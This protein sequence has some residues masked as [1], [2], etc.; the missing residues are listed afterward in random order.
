MLAYSRLTPDLRSYSLLLVSD[1]QYTSPTSTD[2]ILVYNI[3]HA[4][5][6]PYREETSPWCNHK[7]SYFRDHRIGEWLL[8]YQPHAVVLIETIFK[9]IFDRVTQEYETTRTIGISSP[10]YYTRPKLGNTT[11]DLIIV[12]V[13]KRGRQRS[14][15]FV[16]KLY[17]MLSEK[18]ESLKMHVD[19]NRQ[20]PRILDK[21]WGSNYFFKWQYNYNDSW[22]FFP[23]EDSLSIEES[24]HEYCKK[25]NW[26]KVIENDKFSINFSRLTFTSR[27]TNIPMTI[28]CSIQRS[29][30]VILPYCT[31]VSSNFFLFGIQ[32]RKNEAT[33]LSAFG[34]L[35]NPE[36][37]HD[38]KETA[39]RET[40][41]TTYSCFT[42]AQ[43]L[44]KLLSEMN[45]H[46]EVYKDFYLVNIGK[47]TKQQRKHITDQYLSLRQSDAE[48]NQLVWVDGIDLYNTLLE[49]LKNKTNPVLKKHFYFRRYLQGSLMSQLN[50][51]YFVNLCCRSKSV[52]A[53]SMLELLNEN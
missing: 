25:G 9:I 37:R 10:K 30:S 34:G 42:D 12:I 31:G 52:S 18:F 40:L 35:E 47:F 24:F 17:C 15:L 2:D 6:D 43:T 7:I 50:R 23:M 1:R 41:R 53:A 28:K 16:E 5:V 44:R 32:Q 46:Q 8:H 14:V 29:S 21:D 19:I 39:I 51:S 3:I 13:S 11:A 4:V 49:A 38:L 48:Y 27:S 45:S 33:Y 20:H 22:D 26:N 36:D